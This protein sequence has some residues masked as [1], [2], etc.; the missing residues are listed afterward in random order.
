MAK[1]ARR[2]LLGF[3]RRSRRLRNFPISGSLLLMKGETQHCWKRG[4]EKE[5]PPYGAGQPD[6]SVCLQAIIDK[7]LRQLGASAKDHFSVATLV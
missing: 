1:I 7:E 2:K 3:S 6:F 5:K 4:I